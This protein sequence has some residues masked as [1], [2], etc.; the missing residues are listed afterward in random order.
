MDVRITHSVVEV[1][2]NSHRI[3]SHPRLYGKPGQYHT[4]PEHMPD[5]HKMYLQWNSERFLSWAYSIGQYTG[6][7]I[8][9]I[10]NSHKIEQQG[11]RA[12]MGVLKLCDKYGIKRLEAACEK[13]LSY[14][15]N[16]S[17]KNIDSILKSGQDKLIPLPE[18]M[19]SA[20]ESHSFTRGADYYGRKKQC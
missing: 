9:A 18:K 1:F 4:I 7:V 14:T 20:D 13:A 19:H 15:P 10:L 17:Y 6:S 11:Y 12:C 3:C 2:Y 16:P 8:K 5:K